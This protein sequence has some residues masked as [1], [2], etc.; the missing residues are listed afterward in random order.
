M[1]STGTVTAEINPA[2]IWIPIVAFVAAIACIVCFSN[3][4]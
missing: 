4:K 1:N 2:D 3:C